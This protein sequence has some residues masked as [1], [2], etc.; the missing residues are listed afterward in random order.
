MAF[1]ARAKRLYQMPNTVESVIDRLWITARGCWEWRGTLARG[2][3]G[4]VMVGGVRTVVHRIV[5][6]H[7]VG[8]IPDGK[9]LDHTCRNRQCANPAHLEPVTH[10]ENLQR[11]QLRRGKNKPPEKRSEPPLR[12][13]IS[14]LFDMSADEL[15]RAL[16][17][18]REM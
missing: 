8:S 14:D 15:Q 3:Y 5:Y 18:R 7:L 9:E 10:R 12:R 13:V 2:G 16:D 4:R 6:E 1:A 17:N 11:T